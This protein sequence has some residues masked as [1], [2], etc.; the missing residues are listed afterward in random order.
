MTAMEGVAR[1]SRRNIVSCC[2]FVDDRCLD[3]PMVVNMVLCEDSWSCYYEVGFKSSPDA[4][5]S[6][7]GPVAYRR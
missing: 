2:D 3:D 4:P 1:V 5:G 6:Y 7:R